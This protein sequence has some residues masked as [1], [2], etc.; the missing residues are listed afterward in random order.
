MATINNVDFKRVLV[1]AAH[2]D[3]EVLGCGGTMCR[4]AQEGHEVYVAILG[5][6]ITSRYDQP[7]DADRALVGKLHQRSQEVA[8]HLGA[9]EVTLYGL[10]DNRMDTVPL[11]DV[12]KIIEEL[13]QR[14][15]PSVVYTQHGG[16]LNVDH[17][18]VFRA[19]M[20]ATRPMTGEPV[21]SIY[22]YEVGSSSEWAFHQFQPF[23]HPNVFVDI[24]RTLERKI[25]AMAIYESEARPFPH[26]RSPAALR[27]QALHWGATVGV[28]AAESFC[29]VRSVR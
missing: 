2:P 8:A 11:L 18:V 23:F 3:D 20:T 26:P 13:V 14:L 6:G 17:G 28:P 24:G 10:P 19:T 22:T 27:A 12:V 25:E 7:D 5:E 9:K 21:R 1:I 15:Q 29:L 4:L 16:D